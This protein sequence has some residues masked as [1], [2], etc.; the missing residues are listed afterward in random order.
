MTNTER[1]LEGVFR[2]TSNGYVS[3]DIELANSEI[4]LEIGKILREVYT[5]T[6]FHPPII[7]TGHTI[8]ECTRSG[9]KFLWGWD[10][11]TGF[12]FLCA[13]HEG[14]ALLREIGNYLSPYLATPEF[15]R[16]LT[17]E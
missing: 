16:H 12:Y 8:G 11:T 13:S 14:E 5:F 7:G 2:K 9:L 1:K 15:A 6:D 3:Y 10:V 4:F 17:T